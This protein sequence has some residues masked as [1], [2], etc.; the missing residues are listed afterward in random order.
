MKHLSKIQSLIQSIGGILLIC[1]AILYFFNRSHL[2]QGI[3]L[4]GSICYVAIMWRQK[5]ES[6]NT[7]IARLCKIHTISNFLILLS[8]FLMIAN[9]FVYEIFAY[10]HID[11]Y[12]YWIIAL[13]IGAVLQLYSI[14]RI[15]KELQNKE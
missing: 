15:E 7:T 11:I 1:G 8:A 9:D 13:L 4:L 6:N 2:V 3:Y 10:T 5:Y 12:N 14:L